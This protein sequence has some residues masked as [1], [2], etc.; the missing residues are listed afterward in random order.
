MGSW[1][2]RFQIVHFQGRKHSREFASRKYF[3]VST[4]TILIKCPIQYNKLYLSSTLY[5]SS[6][7]QQRLIRS[8][9]SREVVSAVLDLGKKYFSKIK[10]SITVYLRKINSVF[11]GITEISKRTP[12]INHFPNLLQT[13]Q[14]K[15][16][17]FNQGIIAEINSSFQV[18]R[19]LI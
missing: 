19:V 3:N 11:Q 16:T 18:R 2:G 14:D 10:F 4:S 9:R 6:S 13:R 1:W 7:N 12:H 5:Y 8:F 15:T 17:L